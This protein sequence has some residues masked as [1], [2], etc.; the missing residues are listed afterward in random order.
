MRLFA[1]AGALRD[2]KQRGRDPEVK[3]RMRA[4]R[5]VS[6]P[7]LLG[8]EATLRR[9]I[10]AI[11]QRLGA[12]TISWGDGQQ[13]REAIAEAASARRAVHYTRDRLPAARAPAAPARAVADELALSWLMGGTSTATKH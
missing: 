10:A 6:G 1:V 13:A 8:G 4:R 12:V 11:A 3:R 7:A 2:R 9:A 5:G